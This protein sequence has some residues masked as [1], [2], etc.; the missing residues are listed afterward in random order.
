MDASHPLGW[1]GAFLF[2]LGLWAVAYVIWVPAK[3]LAG[4]ILPAI[5]RI[6]WRVPD[7]RY[8]MLNQDEREIVD[9]IEAQ[10]LNGMAN[11]GHERR[12]AERIMKLLAHRYGNGKD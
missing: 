2:I 6:N 12:S 10:V 7:W 9:R 1:I 4:V 3:L 5:A 11:V 8:M